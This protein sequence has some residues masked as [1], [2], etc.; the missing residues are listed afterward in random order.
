MYQTPVTTGE[1]VGFFLLYALFTLFT[2]FGAAHYLR[3]AFVNRDRERD[4]EDECECDESTHTFN[5]QVE[6]PSSQ[7]NF[8]DVRRMTEL[9]VNSACRI[10][11][12]SEHRVR[13]YTAS[14]E[15]EQSGQRQEE[16][17]NDLMSNL[18]AFLNMFSGSSTG[19]ESEATT[20]TS[21]RTQGR[22]TKRRRRPRP[23]QEPT[24]TTTVAP[25]TTPT[26]ERRDPEDL[27]SVTN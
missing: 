18:P 7:G 8:E 2:F 4:R 1:P 10:S 12:L 5:V 24:T 6:T 3:T 15:R 21:E 14:R 11:N 26:V 13:E 9:V 19:S 17:V 22:P 23:T 16:L 20:S 27:T 25:P